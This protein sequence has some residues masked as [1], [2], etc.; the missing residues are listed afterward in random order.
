MTEKVCALPYR[1]TANSL[2]VLSFLH[3]L[4]G[5]Q[6]IK[7]TLEAGEAPA[8]GARRE[9]QEESGLCLNVSPILLGYDLVGSPS[10]RWNFY[11]FATSGLPDS[12]SHWTED[13]GGL[14]FSFFWHPLNE[15][16]DDSWHLTF[17][18]AFR[19]IQSS[20]FAQDCAKCE[21]G[22]L[23]DWRQPTLLQI[24]ISSV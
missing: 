10:L 13:G 12:W 8:D 3:P 5:R 23:A 14:L 17:H 2:E 16:L 9:L 1:E 18:H 20:E 19:V 11:A 22:R 4:A 24:K 21:M 6:F 15:D 7:G